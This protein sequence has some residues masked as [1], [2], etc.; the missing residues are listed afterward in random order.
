MSARQN[1]RRNQGITRNV[2]QSIKKEIS[3]SPTVVRNKSASNRSAATSN[4]SSAVATSSVTT[5][6]VTSNPV[7]TNNENVVRTDEAIKIN[8]ILNLLNERLRVVETKTMQISENTNVKFEDNISLTRMNTL[9]SLMDSRIASLEHQNEFNNLKIDLEEKND[10][11][12]DENKDT[13]D[14]KLNELIDSNSKINDIETSVSALTKSV[15]NINLNGITNN[16]VKLNGLIQTI[17]K[18]VSKEMQELKNLLEQP[19]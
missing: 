7:A 16:F 5:N 18:E 9:F 6:S 3:S 15:N 8:K 12:G 17:K 14:A 11:E 4:T 10:D 19:S 13:R 1:Q 2:R